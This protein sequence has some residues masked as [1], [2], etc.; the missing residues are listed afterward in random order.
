MNIPLSRICKICMSNRYG[1]ASFSL[2]VAMTSFTLYGY[3]G[4]DFWEH[5]AVVKELTIHP[6]SPRHPLFN[7]NEPHAF[8]SP[9]LLGVGLLAR[10][11][12]LNAM[13]ALV[14]AGVVNLLF[15]LISLRLF[16]QYFFNNSQDAIGF[17]A[18]IFVLFLWP[19]EAWDWSGFIHFKVLGLVLPYPSTFA[20]ASTF[21]IFALYHRALSHENTFLLVII[22]VL[23]TV[24][25]L[26]HPPTAV[27]TLIGILAISLHY[28]NIIGARAL[29][30]GVVLVIAAVALAC[31]WPYYSFFDLVTFNSR[32][33]ANLQ[34]ITIATKP[35][36]STSDM[37][38]RAYLIWP[39]LVLLPFALPLL[40]SRLRANGFDALSLMVCGTVLV[41]ALGYGV[42]YF[43]GLYVLGRTISFIA[44]F[45]QIALAARL[46]QLE[47]AMRGGKLWPSLPVMLLCAMIIG[48]VSFNWPNKHALAQAFMGL[49]G[50]RHSYEN[51]ETLSRY[52]TQD[53]VVLSD[54][55]TSFMIPA[56]AGRIIASKHPV[57]F[58]DDH[59]E[60]RDD[61]KNFFSKDLQPEEKK[62]ILKKYQVDY[63]FI[64]KNRTENA[65]AYSDF[66]NVLY[67]NHNFLLI[68]PLPDIE[69]QRHRSRS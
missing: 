39:T 31:L 13:D 40:K 48:T 36:Q 18:L 22:G 62:S 32:G 3:F 17:Y 42:G 68:K 27:V 44:I 60:R 43:T 19:A 25:V 1:V 20:I 2:L 63:L 24:V 23:S 61:V 35:K 10:F 59:S 56:F 4:T 14:I 65:Q 7:V 26:T 55:Q 38:A 29:V 12:S 64:N 50:L 33:Q 37:Y 15:L 8:F 11:G 66:G 9:Y 53:D 46:A 30:M 41:Y 58:I 54:I 5:S 67:E 69:T 49:Q 16:I 28:Y 6:L 47:V 45:L 52:V 57:S 34:L 51:Y 21:L